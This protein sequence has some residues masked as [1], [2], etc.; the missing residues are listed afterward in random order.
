VRLIKSDPHFSHLPVII[1]S[2]KENSEDLVNGLEVGADY[3]L[4][5]STFHDTSLLELV[6]RLIDA[7]VEASE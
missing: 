1:V 7:N 4:T 5:K 3:Y 6:H 2:Y